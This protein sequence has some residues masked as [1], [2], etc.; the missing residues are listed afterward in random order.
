MAVALHAADQ[1]GQVLPAHHQ[2]LGQVANAHS[3][4][5]LLARQR[6]QHRPL[7]GGKPFRLHCA[8]AGFMQHVCTLI[9]AKEQPVGKFQLG[10]EG[11]F[12]RVNH[13]DFPRKRACGRKRRY[14]EFA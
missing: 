7:L 9:Q 4:L 11:F 2:V 8:G 1:S 12:P 10:G 13:G 14:L 6:A 5:G 3:A